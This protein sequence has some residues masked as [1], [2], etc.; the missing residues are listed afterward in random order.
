MPRLRWLMIILC[1]AATTINYIDRATIAIAAPFMA[2][3]LHIDPAVL[4]VILGGF[5][6][7]YAFMQ[8]P[9][10]MIVDRVGV[11]SAYAFAVIWWS[12][13]TALTALVRGPLS[14]LGLRLALGVGEAGSYPSNAKVASLWFPKAERGLAAGIFD[15]GSRAGAALSMPVVALLIAWLGWRLAFVAAG[16]LGL[17]WV[18]VWFGLYHDPDAHPRVRPDELARLKAA[19]PPAL[20]ASP[21]SWKALLKHRSVW[22]MMLGFFCANFVFYF[23]AT[24]FPSY[25]VSAH[26]FSLKDLGLIGMIPGVIAIP[27]AWLGGWSSDRLHHHGWSLTA[28]RKTCLVGGLLLSSV[29]A[30]TA[31]VTETWLCITLLSLSFGGI[32]FT[33]A[34]I[35]SLPADLA[36]SPD[37]VATLGGMQNS[38]ANIAGIVIAS[39]TGLMVSLTH[40]SFLVPLCATGFFG[41][42]G[43]LSYL[44][45]VGP[46]A[47]LPLDKRFEDARARQPV[48]VRHE[49]C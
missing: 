25:L 40:G 11:R 41:L 37:L 42:L 4:G 12:V 16:A 20:K 18:A 27:A 30:L 3:E 45:I 19:Q 36:P 32:A 24:W 26:G 9:F 38:A 28:A 46:I 31:F 13:C 43:A 1:F 44:F 39:F 49:P 22:G 2:R 34:N 17:V 33:G 7:T 35:W 14:I 6:W 8:L 23:F 15:S 47:P 21:G 48:N 10:G 5:F 29:I